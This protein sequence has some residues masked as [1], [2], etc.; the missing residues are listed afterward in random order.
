VIS[1]R[2]SNKEFILFLIVCGFGVAKNSQL[3]T[4]ATF[5]YR[6]AADTHDALLYVDLLYHFPRFVTT[7]L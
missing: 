4:T 2:K 6:A 3:M 1:I 7:F 5:S